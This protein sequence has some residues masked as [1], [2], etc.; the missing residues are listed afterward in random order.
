M[1]TAASTIQPTQGEDSPNVRIMPPIVF[2]ICL[3]TGGAL[4]LIVPWSLPIPRFIGVAAGIAFFAAGFWF[5]MW[6]HARFQ[7]LGVNVRPNLPA[8]SLVKQAAYRFSRNPMYVGFTTML[9]GTG[10]AVGSIWL[11]LAALPYGAYLSL[12]V[13]PREEAYLLRTFGN[14]YREYCR[15]VRRWL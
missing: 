7:R 14:A 8:R 1:N 10:L 11:L 15:D 4:Q 5:M 9:L 13:V 2:W 3:I 12:Y 6:G